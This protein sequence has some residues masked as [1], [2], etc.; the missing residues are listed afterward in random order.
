MSI[1]SKLYQGPCCH[2]IFLLSLSPS[3]RVVFPPF[4]SL[5][6]MLFHKDI[7]QNDIGS[8]RRREHGKKGQNSAS[9]LTFTLGT[10][11]PDA[12][13]SGWVGKEENSRL[14]V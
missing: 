2:L 14:A 9:Y 7:S 12:K 11:Q 10:S 8:R 4:S 5:N 3:C 13:A 1:S 6:F